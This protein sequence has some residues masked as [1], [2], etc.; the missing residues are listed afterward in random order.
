MK[1]T[2]GAQNILQKQTGGDFLQC[3]HLLVCHFF[4]KYVATLSTVAFQESVLYKR[5]KRIILADSIFPSYTGGE[6]QSYTF[7]LSMSRRQ[8]Q[9]ESSPFFKDQNVLLLQQML[10]GPSQEQKRKQFVW[11]A[12]HILLHGDFKTRAL[13]V[14]GNQRLCI[15][16]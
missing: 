11:F 13:L 12:F 9:T 6:K 7:S 10:F 2:P 5:S 4:E 1:L 8:M 14:L 16:K 15:N 3:S